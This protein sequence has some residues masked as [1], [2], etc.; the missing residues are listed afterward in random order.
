MLD[1]TKEIFIMAVF[2]IVAIAGATY[3]IDTILVRGLQV[4]TGIISGILGMIGGF[5]GAIGAYLAAYY[6][7]KRKEIEDKRINEAKLYLKQ[8]KIED[9]N[10]SQLFKKSDLGN[11]EFTKVSSGPKLEIINGSITEAAN[12]KIK[13]EIKQEKEF[14]EDWCYLDG[15]TSEEIDGSPSKGNSQ[16]NNTKKY[17]NEYRAYCPLEIIIKRRGKSLPSNDYSYCYI[18]EP[19]CWTAP[20]L[21]EE[22]LTILMGLE[23]MEIGI[24]NRFMLLILYRARITYNKGMRIPQLIC[25]IEYTTRY[26]DQ[27]TEKW[28]LEHLINASVK[29][30][31][32]VNTKLDI[33]RL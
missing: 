29:G 31:I 17:F 12:I 3:V 19:R 8:S 6:Q 15:Q 9:I 5:A 4:N 22:T 24:P 20:E 21:E 2:G 1:K 33:K 18:D 23:K 25:S 16:L 11:P 14:L 27:K 7:I 28:L 13:F 32:T 26:N 10:L 30:D